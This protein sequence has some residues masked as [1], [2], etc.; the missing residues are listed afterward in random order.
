M[1]SSSGIYNKGISFFRM[2]NHFKRAVAF[3]TNI[4]TFATRF[5]SDS[6]S[7]VIY[8]PFAAFG[9]IAR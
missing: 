9:G 4:Q 8:V 3:S 5:V 6:S 1:S 2:Q 7:F